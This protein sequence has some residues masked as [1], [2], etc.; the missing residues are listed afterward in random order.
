MSNENIDKNTDENIEIMLG[1]IIKLIAPDNENLNDKTYYINYLDDNK[2][3]L[4][5]PYTNTLKVLNLEFGSFTDESIVGIE[6]LY[7][8]EKKGYARQNGLLPGVGITIEFGGNLPEII[9]GEITNLEEDMIELKIIN[10]DTK[11]YIDFKYQG[12]PEELEIVNIKPFDLELASGEK[13][14]SKISG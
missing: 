5:D 8:P 9:N 10:T 6:I 4:F 11:I 2:I 14:L 7:N 3:K 1:Q 13:K 12:I